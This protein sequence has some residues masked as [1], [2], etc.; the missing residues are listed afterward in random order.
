MV[1]GYRRFGSVIFGFWNKTNRSRSRLVPPG[2]TNRDRTGLSN[3]ICV[4]HIDCVCLFLKAIATP[5]AQ[6]W[7]GS[8]T[9]CFRQA[10]A[11]TPC[12]K[13]DRVFSSL[14]S[15]CVVDT[16][17]NQILVVTQV[18]MGIYNWDHA[19]HYCRTQWTCE[20][21]IPRGLG[22]AVQYVPIIWNYRHS[23]QPCTNLDFLWSVCQ[24]CCPSP[25]G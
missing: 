7:K 23:L 4:I 10:F 2:G 13:F 11:H 1:T 20:T 6:I 18:L 3:T 24:I 22:N 14:A 19:S 9:E 12:L 21:L 16:L 5:R 25:M 15:L 17:I 8:R